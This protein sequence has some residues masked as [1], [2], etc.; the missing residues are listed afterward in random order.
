MGNDV[1]DTETRTES[2]GY[3]RE[4]LRDR[5]SAAKR[6]LAVT[7]DEGARAA[8]SDLMVTL[9]TMEAVLDEAYGWRAL[10]LGVSM[11]RVVNIVE[12]GVSI[13]GGA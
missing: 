12:D 1:W 7:E 5:Y 3:Y 6:A 13:M 9:A 8:L 2:E 11:Q 4:I 10:G